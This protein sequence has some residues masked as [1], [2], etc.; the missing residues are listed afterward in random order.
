VG[1]FIKMLSVSLGHAPLLYQSLCQPNDEEAPSFELAPALSP[2]ESDQRARIANDAFYKGAL[3]TI[4]NYDDRPFVGNQEAAAS[5]MG[6]GSEMMAV[7][8]PWSAL[9]IL[10]RPP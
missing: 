6:I 8:P 4:P 9:E 1:T 5:G 7:A 3:M 10:S 2:G